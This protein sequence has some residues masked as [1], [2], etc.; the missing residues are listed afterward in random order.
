MKKQVKTWSIGFICGALTFGSFSAIAATKIELPVYENP[1]PILVNGQKQDIKALNSEDRTYLQLNDFKNATGV[2]VKF[3]ADKQQI[4]IVKSG[5]SPAPSASP[6]PTPTVTPSPTSNPNSG[7]V[8]V[9]DVTKATVDEFS[10][11]MYNGKFYVEQF[12]L[13]AY[14]SSSPQTFKTY[15][16][17]W[18]KNGNYLFE[19]VNTGKSYTFNIR[20]IDDTVFT[21]DFNHYFNYDKIKEIK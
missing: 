20:N 1:F 13:E 2:D 9:N 12:S 11:V 15:R 8:N 7:Y 3:N 5:S 6:T 17:G 19:N 16:Y 18:D 21:T 4:E 10:G 14:I